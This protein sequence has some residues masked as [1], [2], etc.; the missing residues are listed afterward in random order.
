MF[1]YIFNFLDK[2]KFHFSFSPTMHININ[3]SL[4]IETT[5]KTHITLEMKGISR[6]TNRTNHHNASHK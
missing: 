6:K 3:L 5:N 2:P 4:Q 1:R